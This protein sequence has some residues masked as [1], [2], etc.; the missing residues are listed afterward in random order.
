[1]SIAT[2]MESRAKK[3]AHQTEGMRDAMKIFR[4]WIDKNKKSESEEIE[5]LD[6]D[7]ILDENLIDEGDGLFNPGTKDAIKGTGYGN[8]EKAKKTIEIITKL[9]KTDHAHAMAIA[10]TMMNRAKHS[11]NQ[12]EDM[13]KTIPIFQAWIEKYRTT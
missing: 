2:T 12:T 5:D 4:E 6:L 8:V 1:M 7:L 3:H 9:D 10:T 13:K 11:A